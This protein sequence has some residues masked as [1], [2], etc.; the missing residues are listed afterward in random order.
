MRLLS[1]H[2]TSC[3]SSS[4]IIRRAN[5]FLAV[6]V[7]MSVLGYCLPNPIYAS[8]NLA[9]AFAY[10]QMAEGPKNYSALAASAVVEP[11]VTQDIGNTAIPGNAVYNNGTFTVSASGIDLF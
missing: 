8:G 2:E 3:E 11:W 4:I 1:I 5:P 6:A 10:N 9:T 7:L